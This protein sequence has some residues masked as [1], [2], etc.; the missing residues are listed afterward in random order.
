[1]ASNKTTPTGQPVGKF[2]NAV[3]DERKRADSWSLVELMEAVTGE[4]PRMWGSGL[5]GFGQY[6]YRY[7]SGRE[8]DF[9]LTG[10]SP[11]KSALAVYIMPGCARYEEQLQ[12]MGP[13]KTGKSCLYLKSLDAVDRDILEDIIRDAVAYMREHYDCQ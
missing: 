3:P 5:V 7:A 4:E 2:L 11:R 10:F 6:H 8:G 9:F 13:H 1:M 12:R